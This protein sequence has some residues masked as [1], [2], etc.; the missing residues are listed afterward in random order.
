MV[1]DPHLIVEVPRGSAVE[2]QLRERPPAG[3]ASGEAV[4]ILGP[5]D[6]HGQLE[7]PAAGEVVL[8]IPSPQ[9]LTR[10]PDE[11]RRVIAQAGTGTEPLLVVIDAAEE[12][13]DPELAA[14]LAAAG[15]TSRGV[16][17]RII[18]DA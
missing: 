2:R 18:R 10:E 3:V 4:V 15:H 14:L 6:P 9:A 13:L 8:S 5:T 7:A 17:V 16:I 1:A 11:V 12:L